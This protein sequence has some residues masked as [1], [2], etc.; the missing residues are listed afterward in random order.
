MYYFD[1]RS[2][3]FSCQDFG[4]SCFCWQELQ[5]FSWISFNDLEKSCKILRTLPRII[6]KILA[7][8]LKN[9][10]IFLARNPRCQALGSAESELKLFWITADQCWMS[11]RR[12]L[13][14]NVQL[15]LSANFCRGTGSFYADSRKWF[16]MLVATLPPIVFWGSH[17]NQ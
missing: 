14:K 9:P 10:W 13:G 4:S 6:A 11:L 3:C 5:I 16:S 7:K 12:Q 17:L 15:Q 2:S 8:N 1:A